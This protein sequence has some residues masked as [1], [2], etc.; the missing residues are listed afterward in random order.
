MGEAQTGR[1]GVETILRTMPDLVIME[2]R[3]DGVS[4]LNEAATRRSDARVVRRDD[5]KGE[6]SRGDQVSRCITGGDVLPQIHRH[7]LRR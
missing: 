1:Q 3:S 2:D 4:L 5:A 6:R 7:P